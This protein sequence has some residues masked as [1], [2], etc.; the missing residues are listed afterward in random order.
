MEKDGTLLRDSRRVR[1]TLEVDV[2]Q[3]SRHLNI[4]IHGII[5]AVCVACKCC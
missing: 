1:D 2:K 5:T 3:R 4:N